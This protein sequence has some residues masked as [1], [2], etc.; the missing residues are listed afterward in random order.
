MKRILLL[1][2]FVS[3]ISYGQFVPLPAALP[4][5]CVKD[6]R[7]VLIKPV[8][9]N[10]NNPLLNTS[11]YGNTNLII[12]V[13]VQKQD[14]NSPENSNGVMSNSNQP[15]FGTLITQPLIN[16]NNGYTDYNNAWTNIPIVISISDPPGNNL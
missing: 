9:N 13:V 8:L 12:Y 7:D 10:L 16:Y 11:S 6:F 3:T 5:I 14:N 15:L 4:P 2:L 1:L